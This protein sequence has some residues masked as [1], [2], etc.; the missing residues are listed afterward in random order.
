MI[1]K[2]YINTP[3]KRDSSFTKCPCEHQLNMHHY[4][5]LIVLHNIL[6]AWLQCLMHS[7]CMNL[8]VYVNKF[9]K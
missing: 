4:R 9:E 5:S 3:V 6:T 2:S 1:G 8:T 7:P